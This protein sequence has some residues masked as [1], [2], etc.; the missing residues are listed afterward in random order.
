M[1]YVFRSKLGS[2][3]LLSSIDSVLPVIMSLSSSNESKAEIK[4]YIIG[5]KTYCRVSVC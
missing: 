5:N 1:Y 3:K 2:A 4:I